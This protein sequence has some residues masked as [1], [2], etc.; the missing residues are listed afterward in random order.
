[1][2]KKNRENMLCSAYINYIEFVLMK[3]NNDIYDKKIPSFELK[4]AFFKASMQI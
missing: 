4:K 1:M 2:K 3:S